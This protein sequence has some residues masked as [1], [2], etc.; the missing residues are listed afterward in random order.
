MASSMRRPKQV[1]L[2]NVVIYSMDS[3]S[4]VA[5]EQIGLRVA[6]PDRIATR[7]SVGDDAVL[8]A[9][10]TVPAETKNAEIGSEITQARR[11]Q[12]GWQMGLGPPAEIALS[13][14]RWSYMDLDLQTFHVFA[15]P[16]ILSPNLHLKNNT[17]QQFREAMYVDLARNL[18]YFIPGFAAGQEIDLQSITPSAVWR[19]VRA[20]NGV[21]GVREAVVD[22]TV[23]E[24]GPFSLK[25]VPYFNLQW[26][27][28]RHFFVGLSAGPAPDASLT[29]VHFER[30]NVALT[31][32]SLDQP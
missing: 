7:L 11:M 31:V 28:G 16:V 3:E 20:P 23:P 15:G 21:I 27:A 4:P 18:K 6:S 10:N 14:L 9:R 25:A 2:D 29:G 26:G 17:G 30:K 19:D 12:A 22:T 5:Y 13:L 24:R 8:D 1:T 32:V